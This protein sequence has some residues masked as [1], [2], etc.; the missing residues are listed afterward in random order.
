MPQKRSVGTLDHSCIRGVQILRY[1]KLSSSDE[2]LGVHTDAFS[3]KEWEYELTNTFYV[4]SC[5][6]NG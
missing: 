3:M 4:V 1:L 6:S 5:V 2:L